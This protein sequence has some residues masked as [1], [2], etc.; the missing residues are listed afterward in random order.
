MSDPIEFGLGV[1]AVLLWIAGALSL[2]GYGDDS[3]GDEDGR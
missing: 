2:F 3:E 1:V